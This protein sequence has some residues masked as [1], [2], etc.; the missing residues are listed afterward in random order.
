MCIDGLIIMI[1]TSIVLVENLS[2]T[3]RL[4][5]LDSCYNIGHEFGAQPRVCRI[6]FRKS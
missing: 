3:I 5:R 6:I 4:E 1:G 2:R